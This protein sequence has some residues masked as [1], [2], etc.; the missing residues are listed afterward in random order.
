MSTGS[1]QDTLHPFEGLNY[2]AFV[3]AR[4]RVHIQSQQKH[5]ALD[6]HLCSFYFDTQV[7]SATAPYLFRLFLQG[8][9]PNVVFSANIWSYVVPAS[10][11]QHN[12][13]SAHTHAYAPWDLL[14][15]SCPWTP[16][17][18]AASVETVI[19]RS[20][21]QRCFLMQQTILGNEGH[22]LELFWV[23]LYVFPW[24]STSTNA[25]EAMTSILVQ[26]QR[27]DTKEGIGGA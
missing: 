26:E 22:L 17:L 18:A 24:C 11:S 27:E 3:Q 2:H 13:T 7:D 21:T 20:E 19:Q 8:L 10:F 23:T 25:E 9:T 1:S 6:A 14:E 16:F 4:V 12:Y 15:S 5:R